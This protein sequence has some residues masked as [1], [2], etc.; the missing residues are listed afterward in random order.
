MEIQRMYNAERSYN[1]VFTDNKKHLII[2]FE[3][4]LDLYMTLREDDT[5]L[6]GDEN[7]IT[8]FDITKK[9]YEIFEI[10]D[11]L[12]N[13]IIHG[14]LFEETPVESLCS[15]INHEEL[16]EE[17]PEFKSSIDYTKTY[18]YKKLVD[19]Q[20]N[21]IWI[22][23][24]GP[25]EIEDR[26]IIFP[27]DDDVYR[28]TFVRNDKTMDGEYKSRYGICVRFRNSGSKYDPFNCA[29]M[30]MFIKLQKIDP[31]YHQVHFEEIEYKEKVY[32]P[33]NKK[34]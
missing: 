6:A 8:T 5:N 19:N 10:F 32:K 20:K 28:L 15:D 11:S 24:D 33:I 21:I 27:V 7:K 23:D 16:F 14:Q 31:E 4:N 13:D 3:G 17:L 34:C 25:A 1:Y 30:K 2:S 29:F 22:S 9:N 12:Y 18:E 26:V